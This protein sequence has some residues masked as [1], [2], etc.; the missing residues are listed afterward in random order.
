MPLVT[1]LATGG[2][3]ASRADVGGGATAQDAGAELVG[4]LDLPAG[5]EVRVRDVFRVRRVP[6]DARPGA[7]AGPGRGDRAP[8]RRASP[9]WSSPTARTPSRR[10]P[11]SSTCSTATRGRSSSPAP[12]ARPTPPTATAPATWPTPSPRPPRRPTRGLGV[13]IGFGGQLFPA[14]GTRKTHTLAADTFANPAGGPLGWVHGADVGVVTAAPPRPP[15]SRSTRSTPPACGSTSC[16]CYPDA[17]A[18]ALRA[19]VDAGARGIVLEATGAG[20]ANPAICA[21]VARAHRRRGRR[22]H[23]DPRRRRSGRRDL[24][25]RRRGGPARRRRRPERAAPP[26]A[27]SDAA[28]RAARPPPRPGRR[29]AGV[30]GARLRLTRRRPA[31]PA[32]SPTCCRRGRRR[33]RTWR[34]PGPAGRDPAPC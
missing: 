7:R 22:R 30:P 31:G 20:N 25:R 2:T 3:I 29:P 1:V 21:A 34:S 16:A 11:S 9:A 4:R 12:S 33:R 28:R 6:D 32:G 8:G 17:D 23:L 10:P 18:T 27:G 26:V 19:C 15:L 24:R 14:R 5:I 13:L